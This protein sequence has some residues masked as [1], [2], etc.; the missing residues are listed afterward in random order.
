MG[1]FTSCFKPNIHSAKL[2]DCDGNLRHIKVPITAAEIM[3]L[4]Q[5]GYLVC[6]VVDDLGSVFRLSALRADQVL[7]SFVM[8]AELVMLRSGCGKV[9]RVKR[10]RRAKVLPEE[11]TGGDGESSGENMEILEEG[12]NTG[13]RVCGSPLWKPVL[14]TIYE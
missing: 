12:F 8:E 13:Q 4:E 9:K 6:P 11:K 5:P 3:L 14:E 10:R 1:N 7:N 2:I